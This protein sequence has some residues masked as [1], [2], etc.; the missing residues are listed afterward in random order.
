MDTGKLNSSF[1]R[2]H[3]CYQKLQL[4]AHLP[5]VTACS[6]SIEL[7][8][9]ERFQPQAGFIYFLLS[10]QITLAVND[11]DNLLGIVIEHMPLGL[12]EHYCP[13]VELLYQCLDRCRFARI[14]VEDFERIFFYSSPEYMKEL[15]T[16]LAY[17]GIFALDAHNERG[18]LS[19][20]QTIKS[21]LSRYLYRNEI[22]CGKRESLSAFII[23][24]TNLSRSYVY[25]V[26]AALKEGGY[27]TVKKG[28]LIS[29]DRKIPDKF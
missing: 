16:I 10:G 2:I 17:M 7:A 20:F 25:Q 27:I 18:N 8:P 11:P 4:N 19:G 26:L 6:E 23:K 22:D 13:A 24:R 5:D 12:L 14:S 15:T 21:M 1:G 28:Q 29:I 9:G 3:A